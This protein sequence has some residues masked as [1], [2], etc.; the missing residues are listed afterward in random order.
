MGRI[1]ALLS[2]RLPLETNG[3]TVS[4]GWSAAGPS[5]PTVRSAQPIP[6]HETAR[7]NSP[8]LSTA[9]FT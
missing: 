1:V 3:T 9:A 2:E 8:A 5:F 7:R 4:N 6:A